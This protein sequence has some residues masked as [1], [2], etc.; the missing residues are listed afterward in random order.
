[1]FFFSQLVYAKLN[2]K[3]VNPGLDYEELHI[4]NIYN[5]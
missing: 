5:W 4:F 2:E 1:M 3:Q